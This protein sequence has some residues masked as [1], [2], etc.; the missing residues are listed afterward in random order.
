MN[1]FWSFTINISQ[2]EGSEE[3]S[4]LCKAAS[5]LLSLF[6]RKLTLLVPNRFHS[7]FGVNVYISLQ[8]SKP[9]IHLK[10]KALSYSKMLFQLLMNFIAHLSRARAIIQLIQ[11]R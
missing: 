3:S 1:L 9:S 11:S 10:D 8:F 4:L 7:F 6:S 5:S 2:N